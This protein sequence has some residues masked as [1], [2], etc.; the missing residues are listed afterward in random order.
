[1]L[2]EG[3]VCILYLSVRVGRYFIYLSTYRARLRNT[4]YETSLIVVFLSE[5]VYNEIIV[6]CSKG[7]PVCECI[8]T[9]RPKDRNG[10]G[11]RVISR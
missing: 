8:M 6:W 4:T 7:V 1:M 10:S 5:R 11:I 2:G 3:S 9:K